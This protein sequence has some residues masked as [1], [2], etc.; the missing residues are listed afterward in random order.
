MTYKEKFVD[1]TY[2][3]FLCSQNVFSYHH[4]L[5]YLSHFFLRLELCIF[6]NPFVWGG[7]GGDGIWGIKIREKKTLPK[8]PRV[9]PRS[10][11]VQLAAF[12]GWAPTASG[13]ASG[14]YGTW[15]AAPGC[16]VLRDLGT[17]T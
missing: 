13:V 7:G 2:S 6:S 12:L 5:I 15:W 3:L 10:F 16:G 11:T 4:E 1:Q 9:A 8:T 14:S 17:E